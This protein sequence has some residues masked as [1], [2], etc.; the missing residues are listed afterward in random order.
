MK[1]VDYDTSREYFLSSLSP[2]NGI[3]INLVLGK[4]KVNELF[5]NN[6][7]LDQIKLDV[8]NVVNKRLED[9]FSGK[10][11]VLTREKN[12][13]NTSSLNEKYDSTNETTAANNEVAEKKH[14]ENNVTVISKLKK[15]LRFK[16]PLSSEANAEVPA[17]TLKKTNFIQEINNFIVGILQTTL[18]SNLQYQIQPNI[19]NWVW[20]LL[21]HS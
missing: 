1:R 4:L 12:F 19:T 11:N 6:D 2:A 21:S 16:K 3:I 5:K 13:V 10:D 7:L 9:Y 18:G 20:I 14:L 15:T 8:K 17:R